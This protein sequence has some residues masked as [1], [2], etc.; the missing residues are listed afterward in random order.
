MADGAIWIGKNSTA[1]IEIRLGKN[2]EWE[3]ADTQVRIR[4]NTLTKLKKLEASVKIDGKH[5]KHSGAIELAVDTIQEAMRII[6][7]DF[8]NDVDREVLGMYAMKELFE[9]FER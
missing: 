4:Y 7:H 8:H 9:K 5:P 3:Y 2:G 6:D 1:S